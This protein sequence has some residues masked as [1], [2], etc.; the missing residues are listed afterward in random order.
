M[1]I[2]LK[3]TEKCITLEY[4]LYKYQS[5]KGTGKKNTTNTTW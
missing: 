2:H 4:N 5:E 1:Q 3:K